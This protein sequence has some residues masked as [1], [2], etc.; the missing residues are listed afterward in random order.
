MNN[1]NNK[2]KKV[3]NT[4]PKENDPNDIE[5]FVKTVLSKNR[6]MMMWYLMEGNPDDS[7]S[8]GYTPLTALLIKGSMMSPEDMSSE[9]QE[10]IIKIFDSVGVDFEVPDTNGNFPI[11]AALFADFPVFL[12][13]ANMADLHTVKPEEEV[14]VLM[15]AAGLGLV[16]IIDFF[17]GNFNLDDKDANG[18][19]VFHHAILAERPFPTRMAQSD[20]GEIV[21]ALCQY[22]GDP[23]LENNEG[24]SP[25]DLAYEMNRYDIALAIRHCALGTE[26]FFKIKI[27]YKENETPTELYVHSSDTVKQVKQALFNDKYMNYNLYHVRGAKILEDDKTLGESGVKSGDVIRVLPI[28]RTGKGGRTRRQTKKR[29]QTRRR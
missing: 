9:D 25:M 14:N 20:P 2:P 27:E 6:G 17:A 22:G 29:R 16:E 5:A 3:N 11:F 1:G 15:A 7:N 8:E 4:K 19:T 12:K 26:G 23:T 21:Q 24:K 10:S 18:N 13:M 28:L